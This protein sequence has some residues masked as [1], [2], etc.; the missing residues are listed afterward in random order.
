M[1]EAGDTRTTIT[2]LFESTASART[3]GRRVI[4]PPACDQYV[5]AYPSNRYALR[6]QTTTRPAKSWTIYTYTVHLRINWNDAGQRFGNTFL[7]L[8]NRSIRL[9]I[10]KHAHAELLGKHL[11][12]ENEIN[13]TGLCKALPQLGNIDLMTLFISGAYTL[14]LPSYQDTITER[15]FDFDVVM[16]MTARGTSMIKLLL[17]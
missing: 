16:T 10:S 7:L 1:E 15:P 3:R 5:P 8:V 14:L 17:L 11:P 13:E 4:R 6:T 2:G 9:A 12:P